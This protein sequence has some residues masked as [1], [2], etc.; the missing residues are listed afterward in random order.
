MKK[1]HEN[2]LERFHVRQILYGIIN[3][4]NPW[5]YVWATEPIHAEEIIPTAKSV[6]DNVTEYSKY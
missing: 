4:R 6:L 2:L 1:E 5:F 3:E